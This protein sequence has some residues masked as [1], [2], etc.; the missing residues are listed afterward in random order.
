M[1]LA[2]LSNNTKTE[3]TVSTFTG[4]D[5]RTVP[6]D[7]CFA[8]LTNMSSDSYPALSVRKPRGTVDFGDTEIYGMLSLDVQVGQN[9][10]HDAFVLDVPTRLKA[11]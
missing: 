6:H 3:K 2:S 8:D 5:R 7:G 1:K 9:I 11:Y 10:V 4:L